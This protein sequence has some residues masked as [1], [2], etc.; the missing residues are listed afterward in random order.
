MLPFRF[1]TALLSDRYLVRLGFPLNRTEM[2][3]LSVRPG[4]LAPGGTVTGVTRIVGGSLG[5]RR[6]YAPA[7]TRTRPTSERVRE[8]LFNTLASLTDLA[9]CRFADLFAGSGAVGLE[10]CSRGADHVLL[11]ESDPKAARSARANLTTLGVGDRV[12]LVTRSVDPVLA[13]GPGEPYDI[14][15]ADPPYAYPGIRLAALQRALVDHG[16]LAPGALVV[17]ERSRRADP[18]RWVEP[19]TALHARRYGETML[20]YGRRS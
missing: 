5:G 18:V 15:F 9:G 10:A 6:L 12:R 14:V 13:A 17:I 19:V 8:A 2:P 3:G 7:G 20:W 16:W 1:R 4:D 11:V